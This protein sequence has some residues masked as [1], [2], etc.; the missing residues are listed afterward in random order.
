MFI[1]ILLNGCRYVNTEEK[2]VYAKAGNEL[3]IPEGVDHPNSSSTLDIPSA[4]STGEITGKKIAPPEMPARVKQSDDGKIRIANQQGLPV[5][6]AQMDKAT[7]FDEIRS[8]K[9]KDWSVVS[10]DAENCQVKLNYTDSQAKERDSA[11][12]LKKML[13]RKVYYKDNSD[14]FNVSCI[15]DGKI[16]QVHIVKTDGSVPKVMLADSFMYGLFKQLTK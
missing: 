8:L 2:Y 4:D 9:I 5:I 15:Q 6:I 12:F 16:T 3:V 11:G 10:S 13:R 14:N 7:L 1:A